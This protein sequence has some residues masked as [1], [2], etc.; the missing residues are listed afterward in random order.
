MVLRLNILLSG[1]DMNYKYLKTNCPESKGT[2]SFVKLSIHKEGLRDL[3][4]HSVF[5]DS[6]PREWG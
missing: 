6:E 1:K 4:V 3:Y 5:L 2:N